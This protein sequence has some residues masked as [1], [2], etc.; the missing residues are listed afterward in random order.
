MTSKKIL[1][2]VIPVVLL[3][4]L[5]FVFSKG[6]TDLL[7]PYRSGEDI[8]PL[9]EANIRSKAKALGGQF[10]NT[11]NTLEALAIENRS[12]ISIGG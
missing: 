5:Y 12:M 6:E 3:I 1:Y 11:L 10:D 7:K 9:I 4:V 8:L 2:G